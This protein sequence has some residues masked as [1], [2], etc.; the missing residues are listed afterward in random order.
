M[1]KTVNQQKTWSQKKHD[2]VK[3]ALL[4]SLCFKLTGVQNMI[5][6]IQDVYYS[7]TDTKRALRFYTEALGMRL[8]N[9]N[10][11]WILLDCHGTG[12]GLHPE[13]KPIPRVPRD[14]HGAHAGATLTLQSDNIPE[15]RKRLEAFGA[16]ILGEAD[17]HWGHMLV[18]EDPDGNAL[19]LMRPKHDH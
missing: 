14:S 2:F 7:V 6:G 17:E 13:K 5:T 3:I 1:I 18:F 12:V 16:Q 11:Y 4:N 10:E 9:E 19:K 15:D 8:V